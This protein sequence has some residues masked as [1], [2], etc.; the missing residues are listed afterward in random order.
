MPFLPSFPDTAN[1]RTIFD[2]NPDYFE[3]WVGMTQHLMRGPSDLS[4]PQREL[5]AA[6]VSKVGECPY[7]HGGHAA[8]ATI[9]GYPETIFDQLADDI[10]TAAVEPAMRPILRY[11][12]KIAAEPWKIVQKDADAVYA[13]GWSEKALHDAI[14]VACTFA[15]MNRLTLAHGIAANPDVFEARGRKHVEEGYD[16]QYQALGG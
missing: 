12:Q 1:V 16:G 9:L 2:Y 15:F 8:A 3:P 11:V 10:E 4:V 14:A 6:W 5:I 7:C 13:A